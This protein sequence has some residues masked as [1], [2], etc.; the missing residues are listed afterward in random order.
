LQAPLGSSSCFQR[1]SWLL[2]VQYSALPYPIGDHWEFI[3]LFAKLDTHRLSFPDLWQPHNHARPLTFRALI[4]LNGALTGWDIRSEF[5]YLP[6][7]L[8]TTRFAGY[9]WPGRFPT[10]LHL[11]SAE[12]MDKNI[13]VVLSVPKSTI[14][15]AVPL[16]RPDTDPPLCRSSQPK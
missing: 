6:A 15:V 8:Y 13:S 1:F 5:I 4:L 2:A 11:A 10:M 7:F 14:R 16:P 9:Y 12:P 3:G